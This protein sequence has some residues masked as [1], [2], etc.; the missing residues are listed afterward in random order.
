[1]NKQLPAAPRPRR[2]PAA[3]VLLALALLAVCPAAAQPPG[4]W[5]SWKSETYSLQPRASFQ[6]RVDFATLPLRAWRLVVDG[7]DHHCDLTVLRMRGEALLYAKNDETR[8]VVDIPWGRGEEVLIVV[9]AREHPGAYAV[10][11]MG[12]PHDQVQAAYSYGV[13]RALE[14]Y[15]GGRR[16]L[17][18]DFCRQA[19]D[20]QPGDVEA[21]VLMAGFKRD[22]GYY[23]QAAALVDQALLGELSPEMRTVAQDMRAELLALRAPLPA[24]VRD[25]ILG[26]EADL[27]KGR[28]AEAL[29]AAEQLLAGPLELGTAA[30]SRLHLICGRALAALGRNFEA[31]DAYTM[32]LQLARARGEEAVIYCHMGRLYLEMENLQQAQGAYTMALQ[33]GLPSGLDLQAREDLKAIDHSLQRQR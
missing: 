9:T 30:K 29:A 25:G 17:A 27:D 31:L 7:G 13:N 11:L 20:E 6:I 5:E 8:H 26:A 18:E 4:V 15:A 22:R 28:P 14:A 23:D 10:T 1:M 24:P 16:L 33:I 2:T 19:L 32:A 21:M 3:A 12:P